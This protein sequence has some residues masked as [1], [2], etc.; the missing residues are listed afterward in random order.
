M[1]CEFLQL[2][3]PGH[4]LRIVR[5]PLH[6][7]LVHVIANGNRAT[8]DTS[9]NDTLPNDLGAIN[10]DTSIHTVGPPELDTVD[11]YVTSEI[12]L[13]HSNR[14]GTLGNLGPRFR[15]EITDRGPV[16]FV[17]DAVIDKKETRGRSTPKHIDYFLHHTIAK[18]HYIG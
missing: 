2:T 11:D 3:P 18:T 6:R 16:R 12:R 4:T 10:V 13:D 8:V 17:G 5:F 14:L 15:R 7:R 1:V 9:P